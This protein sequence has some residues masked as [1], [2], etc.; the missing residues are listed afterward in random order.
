MPMIP[1][2]SPR[3]TKP[4]RERYSKPFVWTKL[5]PAALGDG[6]VFVVGEFCMGTSLQLGSRIVGYANGDG[7]GL[8]LDLERLDL[9]PI[10]AVELV[11][12][13]PIELDLDRAGLRRLREG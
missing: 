13:L 12:D 6:S 4:A 9:G 10:S 11:E 3:A 1:Y 2:T 5:S 8:D 7:S